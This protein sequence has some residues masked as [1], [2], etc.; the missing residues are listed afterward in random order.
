MAVTIPS[1]IIMIGLF[2]II[3]TIL[4]IGGKIPIIDVT[5]KSPSS[6]KDY[7]I[8]LCVGVFCLILGLYIEGVVFVQILK[9]FRLRIWIPLRDGLQNILIIAHR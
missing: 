1:L 3:Y 5:L 6:S 9:L 2:I 7:I 8:R 4:K